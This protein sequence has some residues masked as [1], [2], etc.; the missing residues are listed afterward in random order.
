MMDVGMN[1]NIDDIF[2]VLVPD[3]KEDSVDIYDG[4]D[5]DPSSDREKSSPDA[6]QLKESMDLYEEIVTEEQQNRES[7]YSEL[8][9]RFQAAQSQIKELH[10]RLE[11]V[12]LQNTRLNT[13]NYRLKKN[14]SAL[15]QTARQEVTRKD[16]EIQRLNQRPDRSCCHHINNLGGKSQ[17][18]RSSP[19]ASTNRQLPSATTP[20]PLPHPPHN[21]PPALTP[22]PTPPPKKDHLVQ[23]TPQ[24]SRKESRSH[25]STHSGAS[26]ASS[27]SHSKGSSK[28]TSST[29]RSESHKQK[30][31]HREEKHHAPSESADRDHRSSDPS[32][33]SCGSE[34][35]G[36]KSERSRGRSDSRSR[37]N[38]DEERHRSHRTKSP[39]P[40]GS[41]GANSSG[42]KKRS[43][44]RRQ[45]TVEFSTTDSELCAVHASKEASS[46]AARREQ[47]IRSSDGKDP[48]KVCSKHHCVCQGD[49]S[50]ERMGGRPSKS[51]SRKEE[52][53]HPAK[54]DRKSERSG[55]SERSRKRAK[56]SSKD[57]HH[58]DTCKKEGQNC[59]QDV[60]KDACDKADVTEKSCVENS[61]NRKLC[62]METLNL[63]RSPIKKAAL[64]ND[65]HQASADAADDSELMDGGSQ[66]DMENMQVIDE[67]K[68]QELEDVVEEPQKPSKG[69]QSESCEDE[70][71]LQ[72]KDK[73]ASDPIVCD[74]R[75]EDPLVQA[76]PAYVQPISTEE[77]DRS[78]Q[79]THTSPDSSSFQEGNE[80]TVGNNEDS[81]E[82]TS[83]SH[84]D[85]SES[86]EP[87][88]GGTEC[89]SLAKKTSRNLFEQSASDPHVTDSSANQKCPSKTTAQTSDKDPVSSSP[90]KDNV[91]D[92]ACLQSPQATVLARDPDGACSPATCSTQEKDSDVVS[93]TISLESL[94]QEGLSLPDAIYILTQTG[95]AACDV[96]STTEKTGSLPGCDAVSKISSTTQEGVLPDTQGEPTVTPKK[97]CSPGKSQENNSEPPSS[98]PLLHD[99]DSMMSLLNNLMRIP[100]VI[101]PL[102]SPIQA[103]KR[104]HHCSQSKPGHVKSLEKEFAN[105]DVEGT[106]KSLD[107]NKENKYPGSPAEREAQN[108]V[109]K[110]S[111]PPS[112]LSDTELEEGEILSES[113]E[114]ATDSPVPAAKRTKLARP[115]KN[116]TS[117]RTVW[118]KTFKKRSAASKEANGA[119]GLTSQSPKSRFKM[120]CPAAT[121]SSFSTVEE[122]METFRLVRAEIRKKYMKL[123]KTFPRKSFYGVMVNFQ[124]SFLEFVE[125]AYLGRICPQPAEL[126]SKLK[127]LIISVFSKVSD[128]GIVKRIFEQQAADLKMKLWDFVDDQVDYLF[129]D[130]L[131][132]LK[133]FCVKADAERNGPSK[134]EH[135]SKQAPARAS[136]HGLKEAQ[137]AAAPSQLKPCAAV[138]YRTGLGSRGKDIRIIPVDQERKAES[139]PEDPH[140][141]PS[142]QTPTMVPATPEK[143]HSVVGSLLDK[144]D[145]ELLTEQQ[146]SC[147]T[148][149]LV[150][151]TQMGE[152]FKSLLQGRDLEASSI[153]TDGSTWPLGT[154][155]KDGECFIGISTPSKFDSPAKFSSK[156]VTPSKVSA[157][158]SSISPHKTPSP[159]SR[160]QT[161][162]NPALFDESCLLEV[163]LE[164]RAQR[165][166]S[167]LSEDLAVSLTIP[168]PL[169]SDSHL[170]F[171]HPA[172]VH[173]MSTPESVISAHISEDALLDGEDAT[174]PNIHLTLDSDN[175]SCSSSN[176]KDSEVLPTPFVFRPDQPMQAL[177]MEKSNDHFI[178]KIRQATACVDG[179]DPAT[180][181]SERPH[182]DVPGRLVKATPSEVLPAEKPF[183]SPPPTTDITVI[184][185]RGSMALQHSK[186]E[187]CSPTLMK[188]SEL[189][190]SLPES[191]GSADGSRNSVQTS[192]IRP[193]Q[194]RGSVKDSSAGGASHRRSS[195]TAS[196]DKSPHQPAEDA[197]SGRCRE[198]ENERAPPGRR[199]SSK[200]SKRKLH[201]E[202]SVHKRHKKPQESVQESASE[203]QKNGPESKSSP[204]SLHAKNVIKKKGAVVMS[205]TRDE[206]RAI[207]L[208]LKAKGASRRTFSALS[209]KLKKPSGQVA[210][211]FYQLM[212]LYKKQGK[213]AA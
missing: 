189:K 143:N 205:W 207:L 210:H 141:Q 175:S 118:N 63:T 89:S 107:V 171:L 177:V 65:G 79:L 92:A 18:Q 45:D 80:H 192:E 13:E 94:P 167:I 90:P 120:V 17:V 173:A 166:Y 31:A 28:G 23:E 170:S 115:V 121:K 117:P 78:V 55:S 19:D 135:V 194:R 137:L 160:A 2:T 208:D 156:L 150:R 7:T 15:L 134:T 149:N 178:V 155:R 85:G 6:F 76:V 119:V 83:H 32:K 140:P 42:E 61:S 39:P 75:V 158:G 57:S 124:E 53:P 100:D 51:E 186:G 162:L 139:H 1:K 169:K 174:E 54:L 136:K 193:P 16:A 70:T 36:C 144:T 176:S 181:E 111:S 11:Q 200:G 67:V 199:D 9:S 98:K 10:K 86:V 41:K 113:D 64:P 52:R 49:C 74:L 185:G 24:P 191:Q 142:L 154:P 163:P 34:K 127:K 123:H 59:A 190:K 29:H 203:C 99:E 129:R 148:F 30:T 184:E 138:P 8:V 21:P 110:G 103:S 211:R 62:F 87:S 212:K 27:H 165:S 48:K 202:K 33:D 77:K 4:L 209:E 213:V 20:L 131:S 122:V 56:H 206:D 60:L 91:P 145:F 183:R 161:P 3:T 151:D 172:N 109:D 44:E 201:R 102:R 197:G 25:T 81:T 204:S 130:I 47:R 105:T 96:V 101:S 66:L 43:H 147:L 153:T 72:V 108:L 106:T 22:L 164:N 179:S 46:R 133:N 69:P 132:T 152:I 146:A 196:K 82:M 180:E 116:K 35:T 114:T 14:I 182:E 73:Y 5:L 157:A 37:R 26:T 95:N 71:R 58:R 188:T 97:S 88:A 128:N 50:K 195:D 126:K 12:E 68:A 125:G 104:S 38:N 93:S 198:R 168:S 187:I 40:Q 112:N 159:R 84:V